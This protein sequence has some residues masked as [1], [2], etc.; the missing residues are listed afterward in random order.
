VETAPPEAED[1]STRL[2]GML[3][4]VGSGALI[5]SRRG[6][7][8]ARVC[9]ACRRPAACGVCGGE[10]VV[11]RGA[12]ACRVCLAPGRCVAC[13]GERFGIERGGAERIAEWAARLAHGPVAPADSLPSADR[14]VVGSAATVKDLGPLRVGLVA[15]LDPDRALARAGLRSAEQALATWMEAAVWAGPKAG[16]GR[17]L[18]QTRSPGSPAIQALI[19]WEPIPF[20]LAEAERRS[21][22][23]FP[24]G[25]P[26][27]RISGPPGEAMGAALA[28]REP[29]SLLTTSGPEGTVCLVAVRP[30]ALAGF[31]AEVMRLAGEG[32]VDRV[33]AEPHL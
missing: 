20:L 6:Y 23:G 27:F 16:G 12:A 11:E 17:V 25:A 18:V 2:G 31:R 29:V 8:V 21:V 13:G 33:E 9:R 1:R 3:R 10:I 14:F 30:E 24:P 22:A 7:G 32:L 15:I 4:R 28:A 19:R 5:V 26:V